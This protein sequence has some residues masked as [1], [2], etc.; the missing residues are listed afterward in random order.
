MLQHCWVTAV[1][2]WSVARGSMSCAGELRQNFTIPRP[3]RWTFT[4]DLPVATG[5]R[6]SASGLGDGRIV[7]RPDS[8]CG[9]LQVA[10]F[11]PTTKTWDMSASTQQEVANTAA[12]Q[13]DPA[14]LPEIKLLDYTATKLWSG[15]GPVAG[16]RDISGPTRAAVLYTPEIGFNVSV[17]VRSIRQPD[18][19]DF[20]AA[21]GESRRILRVTCLYPNRHRHRCNPDTPD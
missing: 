15:T 16:G 3:G 1:Y 19:T 5:L 6:P 17:A 21:L 18:G 7:V 14:Y 20:S 8:S 13:L 12:A 9:E 11:D 4:D 10:V 2:E